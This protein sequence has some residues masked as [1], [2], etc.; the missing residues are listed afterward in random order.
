MDEIEPGPDFGPDKCKWALRAGVAMRL[1]KA[2]T[3]EI[4]PSV[5]AADFGHLA[6][7]V[8]EVEAAGVKMIQFDIMDGHFVP[9]ISFGPPIVAALRPHSLLAFDVQL[10]IAE[11]HKYVEAFVNAGADHITFHIETVSGPL[12]LV[13]ELHKMGV[14]AG[15]ALN[16][17]TEV[18]RIVDVAPYCELVLVMTVNPGF[19]GQKFLPETAEKV[20]QVRELVGPATRVQV[21]GGISPETV[22]LVV[23][24]GAD[25]LVVGTAIFGRQDR[26]AA[27][28]E[29]RKAIEHAADTLMYSL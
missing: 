17:E 3:I 1:P 25:T 15:V 11:P 9:N 19:G 4:V 8:A 16:P 23:R 27:I 29:L 13:E 5:L 14:T 22:P 20:R 6:A 18:M 26:A 10:M 7:E 12:E 28:E 24:P 2:G 21:D